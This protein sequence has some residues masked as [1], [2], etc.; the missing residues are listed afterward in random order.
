[1]TKLFNFEFTIEHEE[2]TEAEKKKAEDKIELIF[3]EIFGDEWIGT[4]NWDYKPHYDALEPENMHTAE[5][6]YDEIPTTY[7]TCPNCGADVYSTQKFC[8]Q[9]GQH[10]KWK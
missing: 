9:C 7:G 2:M 8:D 3:N 10:L 4:W 5:P 6:E 1:M